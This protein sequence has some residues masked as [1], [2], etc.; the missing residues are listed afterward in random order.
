MPKAFDSV[1][2]SF[3]VRI[4]RR[5][6]FGPKWI[7]RLAT[8]LSTANTRVLINGSDGERF[9]HAE[10]LRQGDPISPTL[11]ILMMDVFNAV[12]KFAEQ[13]GIFSPFARSGIRHRMSLFADDVVLMIKHVL[14][15]AESAQE[16]LHYF[17]EASGLR[18]NLAK[19]SASPIRCEDVDLQS[20]LNVLQCPI[21][22]FP[23]QYLGLTLSLGRLSKRDLQPLVD[24]VA[25]HVPT[26]KAGMLERSGMLVLVDSTLTATPM[27]HPLSLDLPPWFF[28]SMNKWLQGFFW[29]T[30]TKARRGQCAV[31]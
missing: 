12:I 14:A 10:G 15:E 7:V 24:K 13:N 25:V 3:L 16:I 28:N 19:S 23:V 6:G 2:W 21:K 1:S 20:L 5:R 4:L 31:V 22:K 17:G 9:W 26:W 27:Y 30:S 8:L 18:C 29:S 11:F